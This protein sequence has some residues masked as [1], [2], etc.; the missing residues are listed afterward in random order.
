MKK[1]FLQGAAL[2]LLTTALLLPG[3]ARAD[4]GTETGMVWY[5]VHFGL[6]EGSFSMP[7]KVMSVFMD[8]EVLSRF[9]DGFTV[10]TISRG[11]WRSPHDRTLKE[12]SL[13]VDIQCPDTADN[14]NK[15]EAMAQAYLSRF[16]KIKGSVFVVRI[17]G[18]ETQLWN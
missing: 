13:V 3:T 10:V 12:K 1:L 8:K 15:I 6:G 17:P 16:R 9:P 14:R 4:V 5:R 11:P 2:L 18:I 7:T